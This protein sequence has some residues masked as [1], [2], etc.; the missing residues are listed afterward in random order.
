MI[1]LL[2]ASLDRNWAVIPERDISAHALD[3]FKDFLVWWHYGINDG[4]S[5]TIFLNLFWVF[6]LIL[7]Y[8]LWRTRRTT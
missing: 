6:A 1:K 5:W 8:I 4:E 2:A 3:S 7:T